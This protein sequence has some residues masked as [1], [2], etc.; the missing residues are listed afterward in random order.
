MFC[1][2]NERN[3]TCLGRTCFSV[4]ARKGDAAASNCVLGKYSRAATG[5]PSPSPSLTRFVSVG[6]VNARLVCVCLCWCQCVLDRLNCAVQEQVAA[7]LCWWCFLCT[8]V[9]CRCA[10]VSA[11][12]CGLD[13]CAF[14]QPTK[15]WAH[16]WIIGAI[17]CLGA[18][19]VAA[20]TTAVAA[21]AAVVLAT[22]L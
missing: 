10:C 5:A 16:R 2:R 14:S 19:T 11:L 12:R 9:C 1:G 20:T 21:A 18:A 22:E 8:C 13:V 6:Q 3:G 15:T 4:L 7:H 17:R